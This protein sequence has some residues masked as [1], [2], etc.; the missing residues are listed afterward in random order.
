MKKLF[1]ILLCSFWTVCSYAQE[2]FAPQK[3]DWSISVD[4]ASIFNFINGS[5]SESTISGKYLVTD[6]IA[7]VGGIGF[8][9]YSITGTNKENNGNAGTLSL[10]VGGQYFF[11]TDKR[12]RPYAG[13]KIGFAV[14]AARVED[15]EEDGMK[16]MVDIYTSPFYAT[17]GVGAEFFLS[18]NISLSTDVGIALAC[19]MDRYLEL[20]NG[21]QAYKVKNYNFNFVYATGLGALD[22]KLALHFYF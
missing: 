7:L 10:N 2:Q 8:A 22:G 17:L 20:G 18:K 5:S 15:G 4:A 1:C 14:G 12:L 6:K 16:K 3:N 19:S 11:N 13:V 21:V 9:G